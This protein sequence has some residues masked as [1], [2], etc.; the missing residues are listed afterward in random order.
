[1]DRSIVSPSNEEK[2]L[3]RWTLADRIV[4]KSVLVSGGSGFIGTHLCGRLIASGA[5]L[6]VVSREPRKAESERLQWWQADFKDIVAVRQV[7]KNTQPHLVFHLASH[8][9]G[10][11][12]LGAVLPTFYDNLA[13]TVHLLTAATETGCQRVVLAGSSEEPQ[14]FDDTTFA[15]SPYAASK[16]ASTIYGHMFQQLFQLP[17]VMPRIFMTYGPDQ[18]DLEKL[19]PFVTLSLLRGEAPKLSSGQRR[20]DWI[21]VDD[22]VEGLLRAAITPGIEGCSFDLGSGSLVSVREIVERI[23]EIVGTSIEPTF[24]T[25]PDRPFEQERP[26]DTSFLSDKLGYHPRTSLNPGLETTVAWYRK[27]LGSASD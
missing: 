6:H 9:V 12:Q 13:S 26:A 10:A 19:V 3:D 21:Y 11:R 5:R 17:V 7:F 18:K 24:G 2:Y 1:M 8:V 22:V 16:W 14:I 20:A 15:C 4:G 23:A 25:L 27:Q